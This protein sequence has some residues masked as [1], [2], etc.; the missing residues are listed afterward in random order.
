MASLL[1][2]DKQIMTSLTG[3]HYIAGQWVEND[4]FFQ[5]FNP[6][7]S[8]HN[9]TRF[10]NATSAQVNDAVVA[11][12]EAASQF[13]NLSIAD[14]AAFLRKIADEIEVCGDQITE[15]AHA[16]TALPIPRLEGER[17]RTLNQL[18]FFANWIEEGSW[19]DARIDQADPER[20]P[21]AKPDIRTQNQ[22][23]GPVAIFGASNFPLAFSTAGGDTAS[24]LAA[25]CPVVVKS[26][27]AHPGTSE[28]VAGAI[29]RAI[30]HCRLPAGVFSLL[31]GNSHSLGA[32]LVSHP[33]IKAV[34]FTGSLAGGRA[35]Y[36]LATRRKEPIPFFGELGS[37]NPVFLLP[38]NLS[39]KASAIGEAW[40]QSL[41]LGVGQFCTNPGVIVTLAGDNYDTFKNRAVETL[42]QTSA[43]PML[44]EQIAGHYYSGI[45][46]LNKNPNL[47]CLLA[48]QDS[49]GSCFS[50]PALFECDATNWLTDPTLQ[51]ETFG[52]CA[53][54]VVCQS[55][56]QMLQVATGL[57][58]QLTA[59][60]HM[61]PEDNDEA[62]SLIPLLSEKAGRVLINSFPT[63]VE[64]C[65]SMVHGGPYPASTNA[66]STSVG[67][68]AIRRF[69]RPVCYQDVPDKLLPPALQNS[70]PLN[71]TRLID[72]AYRGDAL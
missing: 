63:G 48:P 2:A 16:E 66:Q 67:T 56:D 26:H 25:G 10:S 28:L 3:Q 1:K 21:L 47:R 43:Q 71:I 50:A 54:I 58:G 19:L 14:R 17:G 13:A 46:Q 72:G 23:L 29:A 39:H 52:P 45:S 15:T 42:K 40:A 27:P 60:L 30:Q 49:V 33:G 7:T 38:H 61:A 69:L 32:A 35:L 37:I 11:A 6:K 22:P 36:D 44:T 8:E 51:D 68:L 18:R 55:V 9:P 31:Q 59:T 24:A 57:S 5:S 70:N 4:D 53:I 62:Q 64:V 65:H 41:T 12:T 34:G 20:T